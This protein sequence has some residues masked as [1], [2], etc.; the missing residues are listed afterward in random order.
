MTASVT[1]S[2]SGTSSHEP[3]RVAA[4]MPNVFSDLWKKNKISVEE[5]GGKGS[6]TEQ[7][8]RLEIN[9]LL[10]NMQGSIFL[11]PCKGT[12]L[13]RGKKIP[14]TFSVCTKN[15]KCVS[16]GFQYALTYF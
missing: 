14:F 4:S 13:Y 10:S 9:W 2:D 16:Q 12:V 3:A 1:W 5:E 15:S 8:I 6:R 11:M 7:S